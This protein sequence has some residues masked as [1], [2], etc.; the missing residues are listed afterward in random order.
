MG[1]TECNVKSKM[2]IECVIKLFLGDLL[3]TFSLGAPDRHFVRVFRFNRQLRERYR[4][5]K[6][7]I[8]KAM[9]TLTADS[10]FHDFV[11][12]LTPS[13]SKHYR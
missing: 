13:M 2:A 1:K 12:L 11:L 9:C 3:L 4:V 6:Q 7:L 5:N 10:K 8:G